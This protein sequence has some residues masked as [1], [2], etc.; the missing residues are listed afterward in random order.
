MRHPKRPY[1]IVR[2][3]FGD[4]V[5]IVI[6]HGRKSTV[7]GP[8]RSNRYPIREQ[9]SVPKVTVRK[10]EKICLVPVLEILL[11]LAAGKGNGAD[12][13]QILIIKV[14][15]RTNMI[16][17]FQQRHLA[18][19]I[20]PHSQVT[21]LGPFFSPR[22]LAGQASAR[23]L[24]EPRAGVRPTGNPKETTGARRPRLALAQPPQRGDWGFCDGGHITGSLVLAKPSWGATCYASVP[25]LSGCNA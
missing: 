5:S 20:E 7:D 24:K 21:L 13:S 1:E 25:S 10:R 12:F 11:T 8:R 18:R 17:S 9:G 14:R 6:C 19:M 4:A 15:W 3:A 22:A 16:K 2:I 23:S